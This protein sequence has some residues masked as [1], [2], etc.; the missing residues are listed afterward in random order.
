MNSCVRYWNKLDFFLINMR[1]QDTG[2]PYWKNG[3]W[4]VEQY[5]TN[6]NT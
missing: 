1:V 3:G 2:Q 6:V 4:T 5:E